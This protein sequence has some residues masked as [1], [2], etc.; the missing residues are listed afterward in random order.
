MAL[1]DRVKSLRLA[2]GLSQPKLA[3]QAELSQASISRIEKNTPETTDNILELAAALQCNPYWLKTGEGAADKAPCWLVGSMLRGH[4]TPAMLQALTHAVENTST[5]L[6]HNPSLAHDAL[7]ILTAILDSAPTT[8]ESPAEADDSAMLTEIHAQTG[9]NFNPHREH[10]GAAGQP[11]PTPMD[12]D[13]FT[14]RLR[15]QYRQRIQE[16]VEKLQ[17]LRQ[18]NRY[19]KRQNAPE[20]TRRQVLAE[21]RETEVQR[22]CYAEAEADI[23]LIEDEL[24]L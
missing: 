6:A 24:G 7:H 8:P 20:D 16:C 9:V 19:L 1:G 22:R 11:S 18:E 21:I 4:I 3:E 23:A 15:Q 13:D 5:D 10:E 2:R 14:G 17:H 12:I